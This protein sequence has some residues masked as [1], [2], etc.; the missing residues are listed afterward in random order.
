MKKRHF[1]L[2]EADGGSGSGGGTG[3]GDGGEGGT[4]GE[5]GSQ[6]SGGTG[7][8]GQDLIPRSEL[9]R[10][11]AEAA[12]YRTQLRET[13]QR[14]EALEGQGKTQLEQ[15]Q[16]ASK[17]A[18]EKVAQAEKANRF[19]RV[20]I[21]ASKVGIAETARADAARL[22]DW[23]TVSDP[24]SETALE[25]ALK[26]LVKEKPY[27]LGNLPGGA[28]GGAGSPGSGEKVSMND[29]IRGAAGR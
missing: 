15:A 17:K 9:S 19:L 25:V 1:F 23:D 7:G 14:L 2:Y 5:G 21:V 10:A 16:E 22:L 20:Q 11:N 13:Q 24:D 3:S 18:E 27:L 6:G 29:L 26:D 8:D 4:G 12:K 28:D